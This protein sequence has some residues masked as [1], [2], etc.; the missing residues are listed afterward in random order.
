MVLVLTN[1]FCSFLFFPF[2]TKVGT[3]I[4]HLI[5]EPNGFG[6]PFI[7][8]Q[9]KKSKKK[10]ASAG[11]LAWISKCVGMGDPA[12]WLGLTCI[13]RQKVSDYR[14]PAAV[15]ACI[16]WFCDKLPTDLEEEL[17]VSHV[18]AILQIFSSRNNAVVRVAG[19]LL[20]EKKM[21]LKSLNDNGESKNQEKPLLRAPSGILRTP[22]KQ[23]IF[24]LSKNVTAIIQ[25]PVNYVEIVLFARG[26]IKNPFNWINRA[27]ASDFGSALA[28]TLTDMNKLTA[29]IANVFE[30]DENDEE[31]HISDGWRHDHAKRILILRYYRKLLMKE[32]K[33]RR[34]SIKEASL[35]KVSGL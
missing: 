9:I 7:G 6:N 24:T 20:F 34:E 5:A 22:S 12:V 21:G 13:A 19:A 30:V 17:L 28:L 16:K 11:H 29:K 18:N 27:Q 23:K 33:R 26:L 8:L 35:K 4:A 3:T 31:E 1:Y 32:S 2:F 14:A 25:S 10:S 15:K